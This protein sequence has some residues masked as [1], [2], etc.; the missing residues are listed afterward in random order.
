[1]LQVFNSDKTIFIKYCLCGFESSRELWNPLSKAV[2]GKFRGSCGHNKHSCLQD[3]ANF[4]TISQKHPFVSQQ[5]STFYI[6]NVK[7]NL[8][9]DNIIPLVCVDTIVHPQRTW[10][11]KGVR[12]SILFLTF[13]RVLKTSRSLPTASLITHRN[14]RPRLSGKP[15]AWR[16][17]SR[18]ANTW[19]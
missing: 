11:V 8:N 12:V 7:S 9:G 17:N 15:F 16:S 3:R 18:A 5:W 10:W 14:W 13:S 6:S 2:P 19:P 4:H 1:M